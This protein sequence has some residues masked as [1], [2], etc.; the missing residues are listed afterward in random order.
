MRV[1]IDGDS[2]EVGGGQLVEPLRDPGGASTGKVCVSGQGPG[3]EGII[4][5]GTDENLADALTKPVGA[6]DI[7][8]HTVGLGYEMKEDR[9]PLAPK[10]DKEGDEGE[11]EDVGEE[12][13]DGK[14]E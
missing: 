11:E 3:E 14:G 6:A 1:M 12:E 13:D 4:K 10:V 9:H 7:Y 8:K 5:V 2:E